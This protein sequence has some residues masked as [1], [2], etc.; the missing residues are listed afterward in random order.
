MA[1]KNIITEIEDHLFIVTINRPERLNA[2]DPDTNFEL[3]DAFDEFEAN[4]GLWVAI[5]TGSGDKAFSVGGDISAM[6]GARTED[7][8]RIPESGYGGLTDRH[9]C[10]KPIIAAVNGMALG[11]GFETA[12]AC[13]LVVAAES[14]QFGLP[15]PKIGTAAVG[16]GVH[17]LVRDIGLKPAM[18]LL[19]TGDP[20]DAQ[21]ALSLGLVN[22]VVPDGDVL[23]RARDYARR[24]LKCAPL[25]I[26]ATKQCA[27]QGLEDGGIQQAM[28]AQKASR[29][30]RLDAMMK[31]EDIR[32]G[33]TAFMEKRKPE[34]KGR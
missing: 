15:E 33:L 22:E 32:E 10:Y 23:D 21:T 18:G 24:I 13:D 34:W 25:A 6:V 4:P 14:A 11:G 16:S 8:Y 2:L 17:R 27:L 30:E 31:S 5:V 29:F 7:D 26:Q 20:I 12:L 3:A 9:G 1:Y 28:A 19:L